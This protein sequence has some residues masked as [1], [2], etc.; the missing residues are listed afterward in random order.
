[1]TIPERLRTA[2]LNPGLVVDADGLLA[3]FNDAGVLGPLDVLAA[4]AIA[5]RYGIDDSAAVLAA[6]LA[7]RGTRFG[8]VCVRLAALR[9]TVVVEGTDPSVVEGLPW[10]DPDEW[11]TAVLSCPLVGTGDGDQ[12][13]VA[14][15]DRLYLDRFFRYEERVADSIE[16]RMAVP[17]TVLDPATIATLD[18]ILGT[19]DGGANRQRLAAALAIESRIAVIAGGPGTGKTYTI[20]AILSALAHRTGEPFPRVALVAPTGKAAARLGEAVAEWVERTAD[21]AVAERLG[22]VEA[23]TIHRLLGFHP[24]RGRFRYGPDHRLPHDRVIVDEMSMVS[25]P[26]TARLLGAVRDDASVVLVGDPDQLESIEAGTVLADIVGPVPVDPSADRPIADRV[27]T[28]DR[29]HRFAEKGPIAVFAEAVRRGDADGAIE[30]LAGN[31][32]RLR[33]IP[34]STG[35]GVAALV[36]R[37]VDTRAAVVARAKEPDGAQQALDLLAKLAV[38]SGHRLGPGSVDDWRR[39]IE[40]SLDDR[41]PG[42]RDPSGWYAGR[43]IMITR[44]DYTLDLYNGDIGVAVETGAGLQVAFSRGE[45]RLVPRARL[46]DHTTVQAMTIHKSQG[47]QFAEVVVALPDQSSRLLTRQLLYTAVTRASEGITIVGG[48]DVIRSA[49]TRRAQRAS[50]LGVRLWGN[51]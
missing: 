15:G 51:G 23:L 25:L 42:L 17:P 43:P 48:E 5:R 35:P 13:L 20:G 44:N 47:S 34:E 1:M 50:G 38:L 6:A 33:W 26:L 49:V 9:N 30:L 14:A 27:V 8:H 31:P 32:D 28:L 11:Q 40:T 22:G 45:L 19:V 12:P 7:V 21:P 10:P 24:Q 29:T 46:G 16:A 4:S 18:A 3:P 36:E 37:I 41:I 39:I 2:A